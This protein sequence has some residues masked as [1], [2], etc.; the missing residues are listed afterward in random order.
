MFVDSYVVVH[1]FVLRVVALSILVREVLDLFFIPRRSSWGH[2]RALGEI[3]FPE[4]R[5]ILLFGVIIL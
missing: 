1:I 3:R 2:T 5:S 4:I